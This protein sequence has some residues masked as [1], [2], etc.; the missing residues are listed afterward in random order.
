MLWA[1]RGG[2]G[3]GE[4]ADLGPAGFRCWALG[5]LSA[6]AA[7]ASALPVDMSK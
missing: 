4:Q 7:L 5:R 3:L 6:T 2:S 1:Q